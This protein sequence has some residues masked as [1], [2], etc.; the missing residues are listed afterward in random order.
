MQKWLAIGAGVVLALAILLAIGV[1]YGAFGPIVEFLERQEKV[2][3]ASSTVFIAAFTVVLG[4]ATAALWKATR[5]LVNEGRSSSQRELRAYPGIV[6]G[7]ISIEGHRLQIAIEIKNNSPTPAYK[8]RPAIVHE[9]CGTDKNEGFKEPIRKDTEWDMIPGTLT[10]L[11]TEEELSG[12]TINEL[13]QKRQLVII[14]GRVDYVDAFGK[15]QHIEF[16]YRNGTFVRLT[17][18]TK[19]QF[20]GWICRE[21][22]PISFRS[23]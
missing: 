11:R 3:V 20:F 13:A 5:D 9:I 22:E 21:P 12:V 1:S 19:T 16:R 2:L 4:L 14:S 10:T 6:G 17:N 7:T 23:T 15:S 18:E 8:F